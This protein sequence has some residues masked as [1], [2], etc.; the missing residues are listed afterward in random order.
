[1]NNSSQNLDLQL[2]RL[3]IDIFTATI[4]LVAPT[5]KAILHFPQ[6]TLVLM[7]QKYHYNNYNDIFVSSEPMSSII[8]IHA[9]YSNYCCNKSI[10]AIIS[11][12]ML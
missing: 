2:H 1:M 12:Y 4:L 8:A 7:R 11:L 9:C 10:N 3:R 6:M 5:N